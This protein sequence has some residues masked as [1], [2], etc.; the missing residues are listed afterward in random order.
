MAAFRDC[1]RR[2]GIEDAGA[3]VCDL[4]RPSAVGALLQVRRTMPRLKHL[5][6]QT[7]E[8]DVVPRLVM[9]RRVPVLAVG[10]ARGDTPDAGAETVVDFTQ[11][12]LTRPSG[13]V[14]TFVDAMRANGATAENVFVDLLTPT[15]RRMG[16]LWVA[17]LCSFA[18]VTLGLLR[19]QQLM[20]SLS[21]TFQSEK[22]RQWHGRQILLLPQPGEQHTFG[23]LMVAEFFQRAGW[24][25]WSRPLESATE[26][27]GIVRKQW[28]AVAGLSISSE[29]HLDALS[30]GIQDIRRDSRNPAI[31]VMVG[32]SLFVEHPELVA[33]VGA[34]ATAADGLQATMRAEDLLT[35]AL[36]VRA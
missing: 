23:L 29:R 2:G 11:I 24:D 20:R 26:L 32:G 35:K 3:N 6:M 7:I 19:L 18:D 36:A 30:L 16:D 28:F 31:A 13:A 34:D 12:V 10:A 14:A 4:G 21:P 8:A 25:V 27:G 15:A 17:D 33:Q 22:A 9:A 1:E 5:M